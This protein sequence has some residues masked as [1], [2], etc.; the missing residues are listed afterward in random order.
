MKEKLLLRPTEVA[1]TLGFSRSKAY[2]LIS[3]GV[4]PSI[5]IGASVRVP[6]DSLKT[7]IAS[8]TDEGARSVLA[9]RAERAG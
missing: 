9:D 3:A 5:R 2:E 1:D 8:Q 4:I 6:L 7:W